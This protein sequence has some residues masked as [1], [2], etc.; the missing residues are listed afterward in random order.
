MEKNLDKFTLVKKRCNIDS[1]IADGSKAN[2]LFSDNIFYIQ[3][4]FFS[5]IQDLFTDKALNRRCD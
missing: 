2:D 3:T 4:A 5:R 1:E